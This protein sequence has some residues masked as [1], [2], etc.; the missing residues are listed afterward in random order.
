MNDMKSQAKLLIGWKEYVGLPDWGIARIK[1]KID[2]G[3]R[4][5]ALSHRDSGICGPRGSSART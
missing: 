4:S 1:A 2:T 5:S 3:A